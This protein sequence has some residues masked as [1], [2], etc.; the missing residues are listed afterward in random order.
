MDSN[1]DKIGSIF[2]IS[3]FY[4]IN[5]TFLMLKNYTTKFDIA[6]AEFNSVV[7]MSW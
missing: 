4:L 7:S 5:S 2:S 3:S 6:R 1:L